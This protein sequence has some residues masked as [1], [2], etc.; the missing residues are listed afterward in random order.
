M[1]TGLRK[2]IDQSKNGNIT[3]VDFIS[4]TKS[5]PVLVY[6]VSE[7]QEMLRKNSLGKNFFCRHEK[8]NQISTFSVHEVVKKLQKLNL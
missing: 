5:F 4:M 8:K 6:P 2:R 1:F 3:L 7:L